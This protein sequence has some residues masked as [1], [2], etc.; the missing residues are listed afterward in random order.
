ML[1][2]Q[3]SKLSKENISSPLQAVLDVESQYLHIPDCT[4]PRKTRL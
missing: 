2:N 4:I 3:M 1:F